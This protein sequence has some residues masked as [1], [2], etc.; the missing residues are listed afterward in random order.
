MVALVAAIGLAAI[1][2]NFGSGR[3][4][5]EWTRTTYGIGLMMFVVF[6]PWWVVAVGLGASRVLVPVVM[7]IFTVAYAAGR[8]GRRPRRRSDER[9]SP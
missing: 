5:S 7:V 1:P 3:W 9:T 2:Y 8:R 4:Q 6:L